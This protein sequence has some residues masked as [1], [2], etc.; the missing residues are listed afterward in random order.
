M[1][2]VVIA[3]V[4]LLSF[5]AAGAQERKA[6]AY[7]LITHDPYFSIW[8]NTDQLNASPTRHW[9]GATQSLV[10]MVKVDGSIYRFL[11]E[12]AKVWTPIAATSDDGDY[13]VAY[14]E[15]KPASGWEQPGFSDAQW[16]KGAAPFGDNPSIAK[17]SWKSKDLWTRRTFTVANND[18]GKLFLKMNHDDNVEVFL[19]GEQ[20]FA[21]KGWN[22]K[23]EYFPISSKLK[24]GSNVLAVHV[25]NTAGGQWLDAGI[26][27]EKVVVADAA[28]KLAEQKSVDIN[29]TQTI[30]EFTAGKANLTVTFTSPLLISDLHLVSRPVSY[31]NVKAAS[32]DGEAHDVQ[33]YFGASSDL[34]VN[35]PS[36]QVKADKYTAQGL[37]I[38]KAGTLSQEVLKKKGDDLRIDWGYMYVAVPTAANVNKPLLLL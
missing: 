38:L 9:T 25:A 12:E 5:S 24:K 28:I 8:S 7:P 19:N 33:L 11:G 22:N 14:T 37:S 21:R 4:A 6:P 29:A 2:N 34:A 31:V 13:T 3:A 16:K 10:G 18:R 27:E 26:V 1:K 35:M 15:T 36:Q 17:T 20:I 32:N 23:F 30:Y